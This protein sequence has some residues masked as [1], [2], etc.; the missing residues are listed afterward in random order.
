MR[1]S[2]RHERWVYIIGG[3]LLL[4]GLGWLFAHYILAVPGEFGE[5]HH[6]SETW[7]LRTHGATAMGFL[8]VIGSLIP[9]H[10]VRAWHLRKNLRTG[11]FMIVLITLLILTS[12]GL[13]YV[14]EEL[15][16]PWISTAH[17]VIGIASIAGLLLHVMVGRKSYP[18]SS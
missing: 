14:T 8:M 15:S 11:L 5:A 18:K 17:W 7:W 4:S 13:Y 2:I 1:L 12:Y 9:G 6:P 10:I 16:H 3:L